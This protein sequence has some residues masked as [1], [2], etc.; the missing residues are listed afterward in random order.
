MPISAQAYFAARRV[1]IGLHADHIR[2]FGVPLQCS[3]ASPVPVRGCHTNGVNCL[4]FSAFM[5]GTHRDHGPVLA[6]RGLQIGP[7]RVGE[8]R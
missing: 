5:I 4:C 6:R 3:F 2:T 1:M 8:G 7:Q